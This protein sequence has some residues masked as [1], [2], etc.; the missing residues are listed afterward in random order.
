MFVDHER[1]KRKV[2]QG[3]SIIYAQ[4]TLIVAQSK[5]IDVARKVAEIANLKSVFF[6]DF[7]DKQQKVVIATFRRQNLTNLALGV[8]LGLLIMRIVIK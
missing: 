3:D 2:N 5:E 8:S 7:A 6:Q 1:L 4:D